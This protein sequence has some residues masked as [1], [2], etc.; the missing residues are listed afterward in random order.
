M[1]NSKKHKVRFLFKRNVPGGV[2]IRGQI[3]KM[4]ESE[5]ALFQ[6]AGYGR[7]LAKGEAEAKGKAKKA[8]PAP[9]AK[10]TPKPATKPAPKA[11]K[12]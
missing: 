4:D 2:A 12:E 8:K 1:N 10:P 7:V 5:A 9:K 3:V 11:D 6:R